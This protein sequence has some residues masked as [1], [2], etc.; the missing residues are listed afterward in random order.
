[1]PQSMVK[2]VKI[3]KAVK[4]NL[5][6]YCCLKML[7]CCEIG[8]TMSVASKSPRTMTPLALKYRK[9]QIGTVS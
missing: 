7:Y 4:G 8:L 9:F 2:V 5:V 3:V 1:M 6:R